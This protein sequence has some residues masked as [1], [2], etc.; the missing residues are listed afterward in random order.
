MLLLLRLLSLP[1]MFFLSLLGCDCCLLLRF[2]LLRCRCLLEV[3]LVGRLLR[4][5]LLRCLLLRRLLCLLSCCFC[6]LLLLLSCGCGLGS[7]LSSHLSLSCLHVDHLNGVPDSGPQGIVRL[8][9]LSDHAIVELEQHA[10]DGVCLAR[11]RQPDLV[12]EVLAH[13]VLVCW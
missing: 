1:G 9:H 10:D 5:L 11:V 2:A 6:L 4:C 12:V 3:L 13:L 8:C 7:L